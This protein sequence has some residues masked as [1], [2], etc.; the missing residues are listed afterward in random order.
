[1]FQ[2]RTLGGLDLRDAEQRKVAAVL[3]H[4]KR[5]ALLVYLLVASPGRAARRDSLV[6][7]FWPESS[8]DLA[9]SSLRKALHNLRQALGADI[10]VAPSDEEVAIAA[11]KFDCDAI[12][13]ARADAARALELYKG[14]FLDGFFL[15]DSPAFDQ[16]C[17]RERVRLREGAFEIMWRKAEAE[18]ASGAAYD[19]AYWARQASAL[20]PN[21]ESALRRL[22]LLL[23]RVGDRAGA[24]SAYEEFSRRLSQDLDIQASPETQTLAA[25][26]RRAGSAPNEVLLGATVASPSAALLDS[27]APPPALPAP[28][29]SFWK[30]R[31]TRLAVA[32]TVVLAA[33]ITSL[34]L[35]EASASPPAPVAT[36]VLPFS[37]R[38]AKELSYLADGMP[39]LLATSLDGAGMQTTDSAS[40]R[41]VVS[42]DIVEAAGRLRIR[43]ELRDVDLDESLA[44]AAVED[45]ASRVFALVDQLAAQLAASGPA[46]RR[47][48]L[49]QLASVTTSSLPAL[50]AYLEGES[51][52]RIGHYKEA[53]DAYQRAIRADTGFA[54]AYYRLAASYGWSSDTLSRPT[55]RRAVELA[56]RLSTTERTLL[57]AYAAYSHGR[58][59]DAE[60]RYREIVRLR[61]FDG[62]AWYHLGE[63]LFHYNS[64]RGRPIQ[65]ARPMFLR[66]LGSGPKDATLTH[67]LEIEAINGNYAAFDSLL[68][69]ISPGA[70][71]DLVGRTVR[72]FVSGSASE[73]ATVLEENRRV[74]DAD[75]ANYA[76]HMLFLLDDRQGAGTV[77][78]LLLSPERPAEARALG[79]ILL[80]H[81]EAAAG[82]VRAA[83]LELRKAAE[84]DPTRALEHRGLLESLS[85]LKV[86][87][88]QRLATRDALMKWRGDAAPS[89]VVFS[90]DRF[91]HEP[92]RKYLIGMLSARSGEMVTAARAASDVE[93][94]AASQH[95]FAIML[96]RGVRAQILADSGR[97]DEALAALSIGHTQ[98]AVADLIGIVPVAGLGSER[99]LRAELLRELGRTEESL[100]WYASFGQHSAFDRVFLAP[101]HRR[102][103]ELHERAGRTA[104]AIEHHE[105]FIGLWKDA[106]PELQPLVDDT[107]ERVAR[108][109]EKK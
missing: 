49:T 5:S 90:D 4:S 15:P 14:S 61:P 25:R 88:A 33:A 72:A 38:G 93:R 27:D 20:A 104:E 30:R 55:A 45:S 67:L 80:A 28:A 99:F 65:E 87:A 76:R 7:I 107:R 19:A 105:K 66:A 21:D 40:A 73:R 42:G 10:I 26:I 39:M 64:V 68:G 12:E 41:Y 96:A 56:A 57:E 84:F 34:R 74:S 50:R 2:L 69:D 48:R 108:L 53:V 58:A 44:R 1:M 75:L 59:D 109:R 36:A 8:Q 22:L 29:G 71:F 98:P 101:S 78:R 43:V 85:F 16:W 97:R 95:S 46:A 31:T 35:Y 47:E 11:E 6:G 94:D 62:E 9:R 91:M 3:A 23:E 81:L 24:I 70:H 86:P 32:A 83:D 102:M 60:R 18:G 13:L 100:G 89:G 54:L 77:V 63:V 79:S 92:V 103:G 51:K 106:D 37:F 52:F 82:R 17:E